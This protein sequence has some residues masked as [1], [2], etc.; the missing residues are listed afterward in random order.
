MTRTL[1]KQI[2]AGETLAW[3][4][5]LTAYPAGDWTLTLILRGAGAIDLTAEA[6][7]ASHLLRA[8]A[9]Q[10]T[11]WVPGRYWYVLRVSDGTDVLG[12]EEGTLEIRA[13]LAS[14]EAGYDGRDH[15]ARVLAAIEAVIENRATID[16]ER[17]R[18]NNRELQRTPLGELLKLR[19]RYTREAQRKAMAAR[20]Q[21]LLGRKIHT[22]FV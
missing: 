4:I 6:D 14:L 16:Q 17:Y 22:R 10:T 15:V 8:D 9:A 18:I 13:D 21:S 11:A 2:T 20:G 1:P 12:L 3:P 19:D 5:T 7:G